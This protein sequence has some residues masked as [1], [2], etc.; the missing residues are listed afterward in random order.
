M[1]KQWHL[2]H[3]LPSPF[4]PQNKNTDTRKKTP[5]NKTKQERQSRILSQKY[6]EIDLQQN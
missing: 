3:L 5:Q 6:T 2:P 4:P 1:N